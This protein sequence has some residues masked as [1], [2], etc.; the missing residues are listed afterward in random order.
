MELL[1]WR[2]FSLPWCIAVKNYT[3]LLIDLNPDR[4]YARICGTWKKR[5]SSERLTGG[6]S[7][8]P[9]QCSPPLCWA[10]SPA[11][12]GAPSACTA[13]TWR[14]EGRRGSN[15]T[16]TQERQR[17]EKKDYITNFF[18]SFFLCWERPSS[19]HSEG[20]MNWSLQNSE[21]LALFFKK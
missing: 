10:P 18:T 6:V 1:E 8:P 13:G 11:P 17:S 20:H 7:S 4:V 14:A 5:P 21:S 12:A 15:Q 16:T 2:C 3:C 19:H 9:P